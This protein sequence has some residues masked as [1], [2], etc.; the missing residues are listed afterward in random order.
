MTT[1]IVIALS[2]IGVFSAEAA[3]ASSVVGPRDAVESAVD[4]FM[5][6]VQ[7][8]RSDSPAAAAERTSQIR[9]IVREMFDFDEIARRALSQHWQTL[10]REEQTEF[11]TL[12]RDLLERAY[13]TQVETV[14]NEKIQ[15]LGESSEGGGAA[16]VRSKVVTRQGKEIPLDYRMHLLDGQWRIYD[17]VVQGISFIASYRTQFDRVIRAESYGSLRERLQKKAAEHAAVQR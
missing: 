4:R 2:L 13:L 15:F 9:Q 6:I 17:V 12:F 16:I 11:V 7:N 3:G 8:G 5:A 10:Q 1:W 14:G